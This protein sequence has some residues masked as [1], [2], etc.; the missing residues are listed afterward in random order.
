MTLT[1]PSRPPVNIRKGVP[2]APF[3]TLGVGGPAKFFV[4][5]GS[6]EDVVEALQWAESN[7]LDVFILGGGSNILVADAGFDGLVIRIAMEGVRA[8]GSETGDDVTIEAQAGH[9]WDGLVR[10][11][12]ENDLAGVE[13]LSGIPGSVGGTPVQN[14]GAYGQEV[15][16]T[17][18]S[19]ECFDRLTQSLVV[20]SNADCGFTYRRSIFNSTE[21]GRY[22]VLK[23]AYKLRRG[24]Q[25]LL[26]YK[27]LREYF[28]GRTEISLSDTREAVLAIRRPKSMVIDPDDPNSRSAGS[29]FKNPIIPSDHAA[30]IAKLA[31]EDPPSFP[32]DNGQVKVPA[33]W[34]IEKAGFVKGYAMGRAG[35]STNHTLAI[36][37]LGGATADEI[38]RLKDLIRDVVLAAFGIIL[39]MEPIMVGFG[40]PLP[41]GLMQELPDG[42]SEM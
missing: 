9:D 7:G 18:V 25:P 11:G 12:V 36:V 34:L 2:L 26:E 10:Y 39:E 24:G 38:V 33:A 5:A 19:V 23:V 27:D 20:L 6:S 4:E 40:R 32:A 30:A 35:I 13:C 28:A 8:V 29:F 16:S 17:I 22:V 14:V 1:Q 42:S 41:I 3:T 15:S 31:Q 37:N 21:L